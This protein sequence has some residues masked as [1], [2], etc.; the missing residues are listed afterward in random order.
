MS[1]DMKELVIPV[2]LSIISA[3]IFWFVFSFLPYRYRRKKLR[4][5]LDL[6]IYLVCTALF[7]VFDLVMRFNHH[8]PSFF[9]DK[10]QGDKLSLDDIELGLQNK[11]LNETFL[12]DQSISEHMLVIGEQLH[13][14][15]VEINNAIERLFNFSS[16]L[17]E[18]EILLLEQIRKKL[19]VY[20]L[21]DYNR[22][23][24]PNFGGEQ[25][26]VVDTSLSYMKNN[27]C[28]LYQ[29]YIKLRNIVFNNKYVDRDIMLNKV[30]FFYYTGRYRDCR[31]T[32][33]L[34]RSQYPS[35]A[36]FLDFYLFL[37]N[38][39]SGKKHRAQNKL[40]NV[41]KSK[42]HLISSRGFLGD[43]VSDKAIAD[44]IE[45]YYSKTEIE[46]FYSVISQEKALN[47]R[48]IDCSKMLKKYHRQ[49]ISS[50][51]EEPV[52]IL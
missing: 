44:L 5:K 26:L 22:S 9:Q 34:A 19:Q 29:L 33:R 51:G 21:K 40:E 52:S 15:E 43:V 30:Q 10:I 3:I 27:L 37:C 7:R 17:T 35:D 46:N 18:K 13:E 14:I 20:N 2:L 31:K 50:V 16:Y 41:L 42:P 24:M 45:K 39:K 11:C 49:K 23:A 47:Q 12:Y 1:I 6:D 36:G 48:I 4:P 25:Y 8:S 28:E 38:Y 32:A